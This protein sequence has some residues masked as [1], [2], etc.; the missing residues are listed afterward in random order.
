MDFRFV[1]YQFQS[2]AKKASMRKFPFVMVITKND[3]IGEPSIAMEMA[4]F[5][6]LQEGEIT[7]ISSNGTTTVGESVG[8]CK[9]ST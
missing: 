1:F 9:S 4:H 3:N 7:E 5:L 2:Y 8:K 6:G